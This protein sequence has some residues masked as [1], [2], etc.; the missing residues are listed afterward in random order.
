M[1]VL[2]SDTSVLI[3][4][5]RGTLIQACFELP[6]RFCVPDVLYDREL[7]DY[8]GAELVTLGLEVIESNETITKT[9]TD[10]ARKKLALS[11]PDSF[12]LALASSNDWCLLAGDGELRKM[13]NS[14]GVECHGVLWVLDELHM[15]KLSQPQRLFD[16][17]T[18]I[19]SHTRCRLPKAEVRHRL[20]LY[21][22]AVAVHERT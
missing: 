16:A 4:L 6:Y 22:K 18:A 7:K 13:A 20:A 21:R 12:S 14:L 3:D 2:V 19:S 15:K 5:E 10:Y 8:G 1:D 17:L 9:A 11:A